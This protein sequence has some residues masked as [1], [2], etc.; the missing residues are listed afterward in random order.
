MKALAH[1]PLLTLSASLALLS[2][3]QPE[4]ASPVSPSPATPTPAAAPVDP[5]TESSLSIKRGIVMLT[6]D[7]RTLRLCGETAD[8]WLAGE[9]DAL[10]EIYSRLAGEPG[11][12]LYIEARGERTTTPQGTTIPVTYTQTFLLEQVLFAALPGE[13]GACAAGTPA[14]RVRA[15]GNEPFWSVEI[16]GERIQLREPEPAMPLN[17]PVTESQDSEGTVTYRA[18]GEGHVLE[19]VV[20]SQACSDSMSGAYFA[21]T[22]EGKL[23]GRELRGC[24]RIGE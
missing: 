16:T 1:G 7:S 2:G 22:A 21:Y 19:L 23:D 15:S 4:T 8:L 13:G 11:A 9:G 14:W 17:L 6:S 10:D 18:A 12:A 5:A 3:C 24:A 20:A